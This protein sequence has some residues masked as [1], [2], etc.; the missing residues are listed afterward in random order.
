MRGSGIPPYLLKRG[1]RKWGEKKTKANTCGEG[2]ALDA[3]L[4]GVLKQEGWQN[5]V[6]PLYP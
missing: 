2:G 3:E 1:G 4:K 6:N 5:E